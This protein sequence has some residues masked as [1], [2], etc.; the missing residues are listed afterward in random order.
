VISSGDQTSDF[1]DFRIIHKGTYGIFTK[2]GLIWQQPEGIF[3]VNL[4]DF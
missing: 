1:K 3:F 4:D 2:Y